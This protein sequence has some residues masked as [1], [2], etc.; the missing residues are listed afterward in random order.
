MKPL[1]SSLKY[2]VVQKARL[3]N[4]EAVHAI[5]SGKVLVNGQKSTLHQALQ[6]ED[7]VQLDEQVIKL[8]E[9]YLYLAYHKPRGVE[10]TLNPDIENNLLQALRLTQSVFPVG[11]LDKYSEGLMLLTN[12]GNIYNQIIHAE[13]H[14]EKEYTVTVDKPLTQQALALLESGIVILG[15]KT[16]PAIVKQLDTN[17]FTIILTQG[18]NRQIRRMCYKLGYQVVRLVRTRIVS[19]EL[20]NLPPGAWRQLSDTEIKDMLCQVAG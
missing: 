13:N 14:Q 9:A 16:R 11:R 10:S 3:S 18:L 15:E 1:T 8:P 2:F 19:L 4:K 7:L 20:G 12:N 5:L 17:T 6:P